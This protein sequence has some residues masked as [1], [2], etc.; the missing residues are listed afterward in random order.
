MGN[1]EVCVEKRR[2]PA[3]IY[4]DKEYNGDILIFLVEIM[5]FMVNT[6]FS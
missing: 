2:V 4:K 3:I 5:Q 6:I 1:Q